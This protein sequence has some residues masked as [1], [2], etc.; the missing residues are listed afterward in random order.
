LLNP[1][2]IPNQIWDDI[3]LDFITLSP[4]SHCYTSIMVHVDRLS[5]LAHFISLKTGFTSKIIVDAFINNVDKNHG[6]PKSI[7]SGRDNV[8]ISSFW[9]KKFKS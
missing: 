4:L 6:F 1:L 7:V 9:K 5:K 2:P 3:T 8:F